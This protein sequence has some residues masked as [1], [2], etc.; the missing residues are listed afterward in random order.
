VCNLSFASVVSCPALSF[1][2]IFFP[3]F[4]AFHI[5]ACGLAQA[6]LDAKVA[7]TKDRM[8]SAIVD[9]KLAE[10]RESENHAVEVA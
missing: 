8:V 6:D 1:V 5:S 3:C 10:A 4:A 9:I 7:V 2:C